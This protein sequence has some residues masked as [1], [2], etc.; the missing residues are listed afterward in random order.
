MTHPRFRL[1][2]LALLVLV[3]AA[4]QA[5]A[6]QAPKSTAA[7]ASLPWD[8]RA[9]E[10]L[11]NRAGFGA[12]SADIDAA[13]AL[14]REAFLAKLF[15]GFT[16]DV[17]PFEISEP[18]RPTPEERRAMTEEQRKTAY[19]RVRRE[20][21]AQLIEYAGWWLDQMTSQRN[22][23]RERMVLFWHGFFTS[24][25]KE[26]KNGEAM[27]RQNQLFHEHALGSYAEL[28]HA[29]VRDPAML[30]YLNNT[31]N[32][33]AAPNENLARELMELFSLGEGH[34]SEADVKEAA[35]ALTGN[36]ERDAQFVFNRRQHDAGK[37]TV[38]GVSGAL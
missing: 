26:V 32:T 35:R 29:I 28:L 27:I 14:G 10:H 24:S 17:A 36:M 16:P 4:P 19:R 7:A 9:V 22:P 31:K 20:D 6:V 25:A 21:N 30:A 37:K 12:T 33:R 15:S 11:L 18:E 38:L 13:L 2:P 23:L 34:Y 1:V 8:A 3:A 5:V